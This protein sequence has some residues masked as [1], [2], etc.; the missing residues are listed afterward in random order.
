M[1]LLCTATSRRPS[2][3]SRC[4]ENLHAVDME[5]SARSWSLLAVNCYRLAVAAWLASSSSSIIC[6]T[7]AV[8]RYWSLPCRDAA[9]GTG[10]FKLAALVFYHTIRQAP[11]TDSSD[12]RESGHFR[13]LRISSS[14]FSRFLS[15]RY[16]Q[17]LHNRLSSIL[18]S[19]E[20][21]VMPTRL[22]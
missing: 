19:A 13:A 12:D 1:S 10:C 14:R 17:L 6:D 21:S 4:S 8:A 2:V 18:L 7:C 11:Y 3:W 15:L 22:I 20:I 9:G 5:P 16:R